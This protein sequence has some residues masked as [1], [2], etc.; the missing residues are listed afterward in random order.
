M[1][2]VIPLFHPRIS[3]F[4]PEVTRAMG[5]AFDQAYRSLLDGGQSDVGK[6]TVARRIVEV[7]Q[8]GERDTERLRDRALFGLG[9]SRMMPESS[10]DWTI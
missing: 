2:R 5:E 6:D 4:D 9:I 1:A 7:A 3:A 10:P 8:T